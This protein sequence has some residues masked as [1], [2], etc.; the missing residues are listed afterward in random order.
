M[1]LLF[2]MEVKLSFRPKGKTWREMMTFQF[3]YF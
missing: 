2:C 1:S 3:G